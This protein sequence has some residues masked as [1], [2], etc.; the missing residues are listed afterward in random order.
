MD[1]ERDQAVQL[2]NDAKLSSDAN[3][4]VKASLA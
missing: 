1:A 2:L 3:Q 4:K